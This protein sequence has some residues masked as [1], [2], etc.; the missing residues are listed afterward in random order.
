M[1]KYLMIFFFLFNF[2]DGFSQYF[3]STFSGNGSAGFINGTLD[4]AAFNSPFG[5]SIDKYD[6][7]YIADAGNNC[8]RK[9]DAVTGIVTTLAG[10]GVAGWLDGPANLAKFNSP[11]DLCVDDS[12]NVY[13]SDFLNQRIRKISIVGD[14]TTLAGTGSAG[15]VNGDHAIAKFNYPRGICLDTYGNI[16]IADS[17]NHRIRKIDSLGMVSTFAGGGSAMGVGST[18]SLTDSNDVNARFFTPSGLTIDQYNTIYVADA[19]NHRIRKIDSAGMVTT[20]A[21]SGPTGVGYGGFMDGIKDVS[22]LNTPTEVFIDTVSD[23]L[24]ISDTFNN[25]IRKVISNGDTVTTFAGSGLPSFVDSIDTLA[26]FNFPRGVVV[27]NLSNKKIF[28]NDYNN[29][30]IR[31]IE[32]KSTVNLK[33]II[34]DDN[35]VIYPNP[36]AAKFTVQLLKND[37]NLIDV[38]DILGNKIIEIPVGLES[39]VFINLENFTKGVYFLKIQ[40]KSGKFIVKKIYLQ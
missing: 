39:T 2:L 12:G 38:L 28:L 31:R 32:Y 14:V 35:I 33:S 24:Y 6:N 19:Y 16:F 34:Y 1:F 37:F 27:S 18:G 4:S 10:T 20:F 7:L 26:A 5:L 3:V 22:L 36:S 13:V 17:W 30:S 8:I 15:F 25:R 40:K 9:I 29:N 23:D 11:S 21:G